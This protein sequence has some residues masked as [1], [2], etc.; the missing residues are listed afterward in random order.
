MFLE[1]VRKPFQEPI[2]IQV[3]DS[4]KLFHLPLVFSLLNCLVRIS[5]VVFL[6]IVVSEPRRKLRAAFSCDDNRMI[7]KM[8]VRVF[9]GVA[10]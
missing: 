8:K 2:R 6:Y 7:Y 10:E 9:N 5:Q 1:L 4:W 3:N